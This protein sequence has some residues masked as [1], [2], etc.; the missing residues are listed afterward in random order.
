MNIAPPVGLAGSSH[1]LSSVGFIFSIG[2]DGADHGSDHRS[3]H[4]QRGVPLSDSGRK[5]KLPDL[6]SPV[7]WTLSG[8]FRGF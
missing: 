8:G 5:I 7:L 2:I 4:S 1:G 6:F 3:Q